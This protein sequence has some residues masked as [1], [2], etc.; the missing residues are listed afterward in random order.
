MACAPI[1]SAAEAPKDTQ[2]ILIEM[3]LKNWNKS[4]QL[5]A[6]QQTKIKAM[7]VEESKQVA[8]LEE[9]KS[10]GVEDR[11]NKIDEIRKATYGKIKPLLTETQA[12][13]F[14]KLTARKP[15]K[16]S[17]PAKP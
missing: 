6:E 2:N 11:A 8:S 17:A 3:R 14:E 10:L 4:L 13:V 16:T 7:L 5:T 9:N 15:K 12:P 1:L